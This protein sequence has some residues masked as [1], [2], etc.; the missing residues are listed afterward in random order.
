MIGVAVL[1][2]TGS[3]G[4]NTLDVLARHTDKF[5]VVALGAQSQ[6]R[7]TCRAVFGLC[8]RCM[9]CSA[10]ATG[11]ARSE[12]ARLAGSGTATRVLGGE[13]G[14]IEIACRCRRPPS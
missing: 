7:E 11:G 12:S 4:E 6:R 14:L 9:R 1:G 8:I 5:K 13:E 10:D 2:S 3:I